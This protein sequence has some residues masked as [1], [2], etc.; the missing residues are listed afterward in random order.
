ME[1]HQNENHVLTFEN[2]A[3]TIKDRLLQFKAEDRDLFVCDR[4]MDNIGFLSLFKDA[5]YEYKNGVILCERF[6]LRNI[7]QYEEREMIKYTEENKKL[8][9][10]F[11]NFANNEA[12]NKD[13]DQEEISKKLKEYENKFN[14]DN[15]P[16]EKKKLPYYEVMR[17]AQN[18]ILL[19]DLKNIDNDVIEITSK[20]ISDFIVSFYRTMF[21][22][23]DKEY[24]IML[25]SITHP[26][27][28]DIIAI[29]IK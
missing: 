26:N 22:V 21:F 20:I 2:L 18:K 14:T 23:P 5:L 16:T 13:A 15:I 3:N 7:V 1:N 27:W 4:I 6:F 29:I 9:E 19:K 24:G 10:D 25:R 12:I 28:I 17:G 8:Y 11:L